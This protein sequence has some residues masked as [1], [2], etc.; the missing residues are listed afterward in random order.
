[1][2][3]KAR[4]CTFLLYRPMLEACWRKSFQYIW[5][6]KRAFWSKRAAIFGLSLICDRKTCRIKAILSALLTSISSHLAVRACCRVLS[7]YV[8]ELG[9]V[10]GI[11]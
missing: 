2:A 8:G 5:R 9:G 6:A 4:K 11:S 10:E 3:E 1:M 7:A